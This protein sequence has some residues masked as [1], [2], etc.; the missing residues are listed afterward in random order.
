MCSWEAC[1]ERLERLGWRRREA[2][3][4]SGRWSSR[5]CM[6]KGRAEERYGR[7]KEGLSIEMAEWWTS[8]KED[9]YSIVVELRGTILGCS[10][11]TADR[12]GVDAQTEQYYL[13]MTTNAWRTNGGV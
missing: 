8:R 10:R 7:L 2:A 4:E 12:V 9:S 3:E 5:R 13:L 1:K 11:A 6:A